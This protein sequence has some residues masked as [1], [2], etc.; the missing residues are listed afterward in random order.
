[1]AGERQAQGAPPFLLAYLVVVV[2]AGAAVIAHSAILIHASSLNVY[3]LLLVALTIASGRVV[4]KIPGRPATVSVSEVFIFASIVLYGPAIP[5]L[6]VSIDGL[7]SSLTQ[8]NRRLYRMLFNIAEPA[9]STWAAAH[10]FFAVAGVTPGSSLSTSMPIVVPATIAMAGVFFALNSGLSAIAIGLES[11]MSAFA[12]WRGH[13]AYLAINYHAAA[14]LATLAVSSGSRINF[15]AVGLVA[16]LLLL[17]YVAYREASTR[18]DEAH[19][20]IAEVE[21]LYRAS[22]EM[23]AIAVDTNDQVTHGHIRRVQRHTLSMAAALGVTD[24]RELKAI[25]AG[26]LLH[27]IGKLAV[28]DYVLNKPSALTAT[29]FETMKKHASMGAR[30]LTAVE[31]PYPVVPIVRHHHERWDGQGYPDGLAGAEIPIGARILAVVD[32]FDAVTSDRPYRTRLTDEQATD[33]LRTRRGTFYDPAVVDK[34]VEMIPEL[35]RTD[36]VLDDRGDTHASVVAGLAGTGMEERRDSGKQ[37]LPS[38]T[39]LPDTSSIA[40]LIEEH[41]TRIGGAA[42]CLFAISPSHDALLVGHATPRIRSAVWGKRLP[43]GS[44]VSGWVAANRSAIR[45]AEARLD[46]GEFADHFALKSCVSVPV[47]V[48]ADLFGVLTVYVADAAISDEG[49]DAVGLLAQEVGLLIARGRSA[50]AQPRV[51]KP[52]HL[53]IVARS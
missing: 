38:L 12:I 18:A 17:S 2:I 32:C 4:I 51:R 13:A 42:A 29:E 27:D 25:E 35:R 47:F 44:G 40:E 46:L 49:I 3:V 26:A 19:R 39:V 10:V 53:S 5:V 15:G 50:A 36:R 20:H 21:G 52:M 28:P 43:V 11:G 37:D 16:P 24:P 23:L 6:T 31:F 33:I 22:V 7:W 45:L 14:S 34:F 30:I 9:I 1:M 48:R 8:S 41:V